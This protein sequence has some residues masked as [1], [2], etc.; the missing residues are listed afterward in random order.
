MTGF[1]EYENFDAL[2]LAELVR[3]GEVR[4]D[5]LLDAALRRLEARN[6]KINAVCATWVDRAHEAIA[7][8]LPQGPFQG[9]PFLIKDLGTPV[10]DT[11]LTNGSAF[12]ADFRTMI[13]SELVHRYRRAGLV[14]F[15]R[16]SVP[17]LGFGMGSWQ[18][19]GGLTRNP[20][21]LDHFPDGS[22]GGAAAAVAAG[23]LPMAHGSDG[24]GSLR[25]PASCNGLVALKPTRGRN[26]V[27]PTGVEGMGGMSAEHVLSRSLRDSAAALDATCGPDLGAPYFAP[28]P[29]RPFLDALGRDPGQLRIA[30][31]T[32]APGGR[33]V[34]QACLEAVNGAALLCADLGHRVE[35]ADPPIRAHVLAPAVIDVMTAGMAALVAGRERD[36]GRAAR[37]E[38]FEP[39]IWG[40]ID[41]GRRISGA[42]YAAGLAAIQLEGRRI[43]AFFENHD[44]LLTPTCPTPPPPFASLG[45]KLLNVDDLR[46]R[47]FD[48]VPFTMGFNVSGQPALTLP[49][50]W[51]NT[52]LPVGV[53]FV[54]RY[55]EEATLFA[56]GSQIEAAA[57]WFDR[58][59]P[60]PPL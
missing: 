52:N 35:Q 45:D 16:S 3:R 57:P 19:F 12:F 44:V 1:A 8:G 2:G 39:T 23:L 46:R 21:N 6:P 10:E 51:T 9:V 59:P 40:L 54:A 11:S 49:L 38:E 18:R 22:S 30:V 28:P 24:G 36:L 4:A 20:W 32:K 7:R 47:F 14:L 48:F 58:R 33:H 13:D 26:P 25:M 27:G 29:K 43:A 56:L 5:E 42:D 34:D 60:L 15:G 17:E 41:E 55:A 37:S 50:H 53:Q 31:S